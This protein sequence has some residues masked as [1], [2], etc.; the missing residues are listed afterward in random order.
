[1]SFEIRESHLPELC[2]LDV[3][4]EAFLEK[5]T[6]LFFNLRHLSSQHSFSNDMVMNETFHIYHN[7][8]N[9]THYYNH[10]RLGGRSCSIYKKK[11][12]L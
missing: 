6:Y 2:T 11:I 8:N 1:M 5:I 10:L 9:D 12:Y 7:N 4:V 3:K